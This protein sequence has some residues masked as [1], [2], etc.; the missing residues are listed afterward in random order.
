M[1]LIKVYDRINKRYIKEEVAAGK[2]LTYLYENKI[3]SFI[4]EA[5]IKK[6][7]FQKIV[8]FFADL[9]LSKYFINKFINKHGISMEEA[10][11]NIGDFKSFNDFFTRR[12][13][14]PSR[15]FL[16]YESIKNNEEEKKKREG[17]FISPGDGRLSIKMINEDESFIVKGVEYSYKDFILDK[18]YNMVICLRLNPT[19]YHRFHYPISARKSANTKVRGKYYSVN[20]ISLKKHP[21]VFWVNKKESFY[22]NR[23]SLS[24]LF[25]AVGA[26]SVGSILMK[27]EGIKDV[28]LGEE[29]GYFKF[30]GSTILLFINKDSF[31]LDEELVKIAQNNEVLI[32]MGEIIGTIKG[33]LT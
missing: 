19:D 9:P 14:E 24:I 16:T 15:N 23:E 13:K 26:T 27:D 21:E 7:C 2:S 22:L 11:N 32:K 10:L 3:G 28:I 8:G 6:Y 20:P 1:K 17:L 4:L 12:L 33:A 5:L 18:D 31:N 29:A 30:G 25:V